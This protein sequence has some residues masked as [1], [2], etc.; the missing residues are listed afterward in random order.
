MLTSDK[1]MDEELRKAINEIARTL[2]EI[3][4]KVDQANMRLDHLIK[5][6]RDDRQAFEL[7]RPYDPFRDTWEE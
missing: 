7:S 6:Y 1:C 3:S 2:E 4:H 5:T